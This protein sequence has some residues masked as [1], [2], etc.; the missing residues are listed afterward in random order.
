M[1]VYRFSF[2]LVLLFQSDS[3]KKDEDSEDTVEP[4]PQISDFVIDD[5][6]K[7][8]TH[9]VLNN[10]RLGVNTPKNLDVT[11]IKYNTNCILL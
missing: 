3:S 7:Y 5:L 10:G 8:V 9:R 6:R 1:L 11:D 4:V 2:V